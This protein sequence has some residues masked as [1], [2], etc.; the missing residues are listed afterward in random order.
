[1]QKIHRSKS[2]D[3]YNQIDYVVHDDQFTLNK[4]SGTT[5]YYYHCDCELRGK[6][7]E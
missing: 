5:K 2:R 7:N 6:K 1:M 4:A 3:L